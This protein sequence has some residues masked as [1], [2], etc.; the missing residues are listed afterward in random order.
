MAIAQ[1]NAIPEWAPGAPTL[2]LRTQLVSRVAWRIWSVLGRPRPM[3]GQ[4]ATPAKG[5]V[6]DGRGFPVRTMERFSVANGVPAL[7]GVSP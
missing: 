2:P 6:A 4:A 5:G 1:R 7:T 3:H